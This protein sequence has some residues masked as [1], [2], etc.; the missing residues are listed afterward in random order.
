M[1]SSPGVLWLSHCGFDDHS[2][3]EAGEV[4]AKLDACLVDSDLALSPHWSC[5]G[6]TRCNEPVAGDRVTRGFLYILLGRLLHAA[7][8]CSRTGSRVLPLDRAASRMAASTRHAG[9]GAHF[10]CCIQHM[11]SDSLLRFE[12]NCN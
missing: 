9:S 5:T 3:G 6:A 4:G 12:R 10:C 1:A 2:P 8:V 11:V 7:E